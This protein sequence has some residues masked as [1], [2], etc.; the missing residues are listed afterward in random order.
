[1]DDNSFSSQNSSNNM[2]GTSDNS[3][4]SE[5]TNTDTSNL[6]Q[7][8]LQYKP[9]TKSSIPNIN[10]MPSYLVPSLLEEP[11]VKCGEFEKM[12]DIL[13]H[14]IEEEINSIRKNNNPVNTEQH[15]KNTKNVVLSMYSCINCVIENI[16]NNEPTDC[17]KDVT[18]ENTPTPQASE[19]NYTFYD[20]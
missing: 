10:D 1:M 17:L 3:S 19:T 14:D 9:P 4:L 16:R 7:E 12:V 8:T 2:S 6:S 18:Q 13:I 20:S 15:I 5:T 11:E